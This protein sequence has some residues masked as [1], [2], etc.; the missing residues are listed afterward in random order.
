MPIALA[1]RHHRLPRYRPGLTLGLVAAGVGGVHWWEQQLPLKLQ[2]AASAGRPRRPHPL[3]RPIGLPAARRQSPPGTGALPPAQGHPALASA[4]VGGSDE[5]A[6]ATGELK[7]QPPRGP[8]PT[9]RMATAVGSPG[10]GPVPTGR[11]AGG[12]G[13]RRR[14]S[15][16]ITAAMARPWATPCA[17]AGPAT[18]F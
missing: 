5:T 14:R 8:T 11:S 16:P 1:L 9:G 3:R 18:G 2:E 6:A 4:A 13:R 17:T 7:R 12:P 15:T 10:P